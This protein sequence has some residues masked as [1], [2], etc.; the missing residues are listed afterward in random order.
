MIR[1]TQEHHDIREMVAS[2]ASNELT[3]RAER[4]DAEPRFPKDSFGELGRLGLLGAFVPEEYG[5]TGGDLL[6][7]MLILEELASGCAATALVAAAHGVESVLAVRDFGDE[8]QR[9]RW[10]PQLATGGVFA[11]LGLTE[12]EADSRPGTLATTAQP[13]GDGWILRGTKHLVPGARDA[14]VF[15]VAARMPAMADSPAGTPG[16]DEA[17]AGLF[18]VEGGAQAKGVSVHGGPGTLGARGAGLATVAFDGCRVLASAHLRGAGS[19]GIVSAVERVALAAIGVGLAKS[20]SRFAREYAEKRTAFGGP[21]SRFEALRNMMV[22]AATNTEA[23]ALLV[24]RAALRF[25]SG[26]SFARDSAMARVFTS[27]ATYRATK[28]AVQILGGNGFSREYPVERM[29]RD[30]QTLE[31]LG[32]RPEVP[33]AIIAASLIGD[34]T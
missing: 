3:P 4:V 32:A 22:D 29:Y 18:L 16:G 6:A 2:F 17:G 21:I 10:L 20:A 5:G 33:R 25:G 12:P 28:N 24:Y 34:G 19:V 14:G 1:F 9:R 8:E 15:V 7:S 26:E 23:A 30:A 31:V 13:D 27:D 11:T